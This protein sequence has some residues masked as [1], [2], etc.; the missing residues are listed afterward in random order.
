MPWELGFDIF[1]QIL[2]LRE[3]FILKIT[4]WLKI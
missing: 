1:A 2:K 3:C 4:Q